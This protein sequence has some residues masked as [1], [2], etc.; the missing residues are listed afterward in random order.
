L[1]ASLDGRLLVLESL[2]NRVQAFDVDG[3]PVACFRITDQNPPPPDATPD[4]S[5][6]QSTMALID[7][8]NSVKYLDLAV[9]SKGYIYILSYQDDGS[10]ASQYKVDIY[11]PDGS[12]LVTTPGVA[13]GAITVDLLR[14]LYTLNYEVILGEN[15]RTEPSVSMWIPPAPST[16]RSRSF[17]SSSLDYLR[18]R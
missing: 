10:R 17:R 11:N 2:N 4:P 15:D 8:K 3:V 16:T 1:G 14:D 12:F 18:R 9:E 13:A 6:F 7:E 5:G